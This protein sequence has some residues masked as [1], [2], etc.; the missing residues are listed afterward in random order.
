MSRAK[1]SRA[2]LAVETIWDEEGWAD[3]PAPTLP[4]VSPSVVRKLAPEHSAVVG[5]TTVN[6]AI[7]PRSDGL[8]MV[9]FMTGRDATGALLPNGATSYWTWNYNTPAIY[10]T[11]RATEFSTTTVTYAFNPNSAWSQ[12]EQ[13]SFS[14]A[15]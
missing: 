13:D 14:G 4:V 1:P 12:A 11:N 15:L 9:T 6:A 10:G 3:L 8:A 2:D 7:A 5:S